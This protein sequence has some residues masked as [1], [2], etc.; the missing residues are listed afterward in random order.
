MFP[1][2]SALSFLLLLGAGAMDGVDA[3]SSSL[4][5]RG[6]MQ[7]A[8]GTVQFMG[9]APK[10]CRSQKN[11]DFD[12]NALRAMRDDLCNNPK[13]MD[14]INAG[15]HN[16]N[17]GYQMIREGKPRTEYLIYT[18]DTTDTYNNSICV[19]ATDA[20]IEGCMKQGWEMGTW[21]ALTDDERFNTNGQFLA[22]WVPK[23]A[24]KRI[25][26]DERPYPPPKRSDIETNTTA[27]EKLPEIRG[28]VD[29]L[30]F[31]NGMYMINGEPYMVEIEGDPFNRN[32]GKSLDTTRFER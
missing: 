23:P 26:R 3:S 15:G 1:L 28:P 16:G 17:L 13:G 20:I 9:F 31:A 4:A 8:D 24:G 21:S 10:C 29:K 6:D 11:L 12:E 30:E 7:K 5:A 2:S 19:G 22:M 18:S 32:H 27:Y 14:Q 25:R